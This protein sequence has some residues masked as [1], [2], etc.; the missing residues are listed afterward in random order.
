MIKTVV[1]EH[2]WEPTKIDSLFVDSLDYDGLVF[3]YNDIRAMHKE[4]KT[5]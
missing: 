3:W 2:H 1:R 5:K 4:L